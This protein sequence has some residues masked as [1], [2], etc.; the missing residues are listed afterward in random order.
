MPWRSRGRRS[1]S[2]SPARR[3]GD[4]VRPVAVDL[5]RAHV[6]ERRL[7]GQLRRAASSRF[8]VPTALVSKSSN[9]IA[10]ARS[11]EGCAAAW[12]ITSGRSSAIRLEH[13]LTVA[14]VEL[15]VPERRKLS[16]EPLLVPARVALRPEE[17]GAL[18]VVDA[19]DLIALVREVPA[20]FAADQARGAGH[21][22]GVLGRHQ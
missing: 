13:S 2:A 18:V 17:D 21:K 15:V 11:W 3:S 20:H 7:S 9:G 22:D 14:D 12:T 10:A 6:D 8:S 4:A 1:P 16:L 5:V 19:V